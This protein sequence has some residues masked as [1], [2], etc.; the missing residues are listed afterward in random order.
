[1]K[2]LAAILIVL[3]LFF[4]CTSKTGDMQ[5]QAREPSPNVELSPSTEKTRS[6]VFTGT[7]TMIAGDAWTVDKQT[8][9]LDSHT[10]IE[11][12]INPGRVVRIFGRQGPE[13]VRAE[14]IELLE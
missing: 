4:A 8:V 1:M 14:R 13:G 5:S 6:L 9:T 12:T 3:I 11:E 2:Y 10:I 7:V